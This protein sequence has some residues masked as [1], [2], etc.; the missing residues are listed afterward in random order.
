MLLDHFAAAQ[1]RL[2]GLN[3]GESFGC[4]N[5]HLRFDDNN[6]IAFQIAAWRVGRLQDFAFALC[7]SYL[8][9]NE[10][11]AVGTQLGGIVLHERLPHV[12]P[13][14]FVEQFDHEGC[15]ARTA[16]QSSL[17]G[18]ALEKVCVYARQLEVASN[19]LVG[20][21]HE[22]LALVAVHGAACYLEVAICVGRK[23]LVHLLDFQSVA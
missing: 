22:I 12:E 8:V 5:R 7:K 6:P 11:S 18:Y 16:S 20:L 15:V 1:L 3:L 17:H 14:P 23:L 4:G 9:A 19:E 10:E 21:D 2:V 13:E